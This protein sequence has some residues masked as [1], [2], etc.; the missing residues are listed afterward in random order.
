MENLL[1]LNWFL[2]LVLQ[3]FNYSHP[4]W[5]IR[6]TWANFLQYVGCYFSEHKIITRHYNHPLKLYIIFPEGNKTE[7]LSFKISLG[8]ISILGPET[9]PTQKVTWPHP[10]KKFAL[11]WKFSRVA[12]IFGQDVGQDAIFFSCRSNMA[13]VDL[14]LGKVRLVL[15]RLD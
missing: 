3:N 10:L 2:K 15:D 5:K 6:S 7:S 11:G 13:Q 4:L 12:S 8:L 9:E 1:Q 14:I